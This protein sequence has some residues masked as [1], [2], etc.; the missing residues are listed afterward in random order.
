VYNFN[1]SPT[2]S[3][4]NNTNNVQNWS[5][6]LSSLTNIDNDSA[7]NYLSVIDTNSWGILETTKDKLPLNDD[8]Q[9]RQLQSIIYTPDGVYLLLS[10]S[11][12]QCHCQTLQTIPLRTTFEIY[13]SETLDYLKQINTNIY[14]CPHH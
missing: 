1:T 9:Q 6:K 8:N 11:D 7:R 14:T 2:L 4:T 3:S 10:F 5:F 12:T 13:N